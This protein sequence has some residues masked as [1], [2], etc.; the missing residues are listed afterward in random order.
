MYTVPTKKLMLST[1]VPS[2]MLR[3]LHLWKS[4]PRQAH[5]NNQNQT[6]QN[7][8]VA[9]GSVNIADDSQNRNQVLI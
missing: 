5:L 4:L 6:F 8:D 1:C 9:A 3:H 2:Y 7:V